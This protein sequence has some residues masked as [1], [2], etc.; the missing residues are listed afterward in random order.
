MRLLTRDYGDSNSPSYCL[1]W[2]EVCIDIMYYQ[3]EANVDL[4][5][6][7]KKTKKDYYH[8][9]LKLILN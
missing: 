4:N 1:C 5:E 7:E 3:W 2:Y 9:D 6:N 8:K